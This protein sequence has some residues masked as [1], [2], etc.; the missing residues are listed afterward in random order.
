MRQAKIVGDKQIAEWLQKFTFPSEVAAGRWNKLRKSG[1]Q[2][3]IGH[4]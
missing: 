2:K 1:M 4:A 3:K